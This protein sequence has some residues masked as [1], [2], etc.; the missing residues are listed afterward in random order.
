M[1]KISDQFPPIYNDICAAF[2]LQGVK[3]IF[4]WGD[5]IFNPHGIHIPSELIV[6]EKVHMERQDGDPGAWWQKY[7]ANREFRF[8][9]E[10]LAHAAELTFMVES[11]FS[12]RHQRRAAAV[13]IAQKLA[14]RL[15]GF[16]ISVRDARVAIEFN[17]R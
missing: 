9:E 15:Y 17:I 13:V 16:G 3:P 14:H 12:S 6:H 2:N 11:G 1:V 7:I 4:A 8:N 5:T 10:V